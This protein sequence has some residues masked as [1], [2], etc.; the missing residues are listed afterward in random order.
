MLGIF[1]SGIGGLT[2]VK[3]FLDWFKR[4]HLSYQ[5]LYFGD[6]ARTPY[7]N[8]GE[9]IIKQYA[10]E[11]ARLLIE[12]GA[13]II[14]IACN[15]ASAV[16]TEYLKNNLSV[17]VFEVV[18]PAAQKAVE[19]TRNNR[20]GILG[21]RA[22]INSNIYD[23]LIKEYSAKLHKKISVFKNN[24][25]LLVPLVEE[26]WLETVETKKIIRKY[27]LP[28]KMAQVDTIVLACT[29]YP[30]LLKEIEAKL[31]KRIKLVDPALEVVSVMKKYL[32]DNPSVEQG[33][34]CSSKHQFLV[35]DLTDRIENL[36][37]RWL[38]EKI[39]LDKVDLK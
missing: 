2:V 14:V 10:L 24:A 17:P 9:E 34:S 16:A 35:S 19:I 29:H 32:K 28:L 26:G 33:L 21:T 7:G 18:S 4:D 23:R 8:R 11:D 15:T 1:D 37:T 5:L 6:T 3:K 31:N 38:G 13:K 36:A 22:T 20:I 25:T 30:F 27:L 12:R 39:K